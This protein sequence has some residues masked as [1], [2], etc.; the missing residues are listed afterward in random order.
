[1]P[2]IQITM[3]EGRTV[4]QKRELARELTDTF[5]RVA[6]AKPGSIWVTFDELP[7]DSWATGGT[8]LA[9]QQ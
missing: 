6:G 3:V 7:A 4:E 5:A 9:D 1:M 2:L 8:L